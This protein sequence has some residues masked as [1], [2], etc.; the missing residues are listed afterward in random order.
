MLSILL[1]IYNYN[2]LPLV[3]EL[4]KQCVEC[5]IDFEILCQDDASNSHFNIENEKI[6]FLSNCN[7]S[8]LKENVGFRENKNILASRAKYNYF[9]IMDGDC[10]IINNNFIRNY[11][12]NIDGFDAI[13]GGRLHP[14]KC[15]S[16]KQK[17]RWKYGKFIEDKSCEN[18]K[19]SPYQSLLFNNTVISKSLFNTIKFDGN[20][21]KYGHDDT[22]F[23]FKLMKLQSKI[24]H[25]ENPVEHNDIDE[26]LVYIN[27]TKASL[28]NLLDLYNDKKVDDNYIKMLRFFKFLKSTKLSFLISNIYL[29]FKN[30]INKNLKGN[31]PKL[32]VFNTF[33]IG[34]LC[35]LKQ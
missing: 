32:W 7:F 6:N 16:D 35:S 30:P 4:H 26:N 20:I 22:L 14:K 18:R 3:A 17:L 28:E 5:G 33:R 2:L 31:N 21:K 19:K 12:D 10:N 8:I 27:K 11:I 23:S 9:L 13:Y 15:P 25:I 34:Y 29:L 1:T 24:K